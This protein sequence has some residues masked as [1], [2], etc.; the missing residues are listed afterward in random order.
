[1]FTSLCNML[2]L[3]VDMTDL[4]AVACTQYLITMLT[5]WNSWS[6][7]HNLLGNSALPSSELSLYY[8]VIFS[9]SKI[10]NP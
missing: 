10:I 3:L 5:F 4:C 8:T 1:M 2:M 9:Y 7:V 6:A